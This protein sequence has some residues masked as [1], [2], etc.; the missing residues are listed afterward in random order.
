MALHHF[1]R[2]V[3]DGLVLCL[4]AGNPLSYTPGDSVWKDLSGLG[5]NGTLIGGVGYDSN[6]RGFLVFDGV[7][8]YIS[9]SNLTLNFNNG[10]T[11]SQWLKVI[12]ISS[13]NL[14]SFQYRNGLNNIN[15]LFLTN[16]SI[17]LE[18]YGSGG[19]LY[20]AAESFELNKWYN[21]TCTFSGTDTDGGSGMSTIYLNGI[22]IASGTRNGFNSTTADIIVGAYPASAHYFNGYISN[23]QFYNKCLTSQQILDNYSA[24]KGRYGL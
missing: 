4:D 24:T 14:G 13:T 17:R 15:I 3:A 2:I 11:I 12:N 1:P 10:F 8:D 21:L 7:N 18:S 6:N 22:S 19:Q 16:G 20:S 23:N 5:N 9:I